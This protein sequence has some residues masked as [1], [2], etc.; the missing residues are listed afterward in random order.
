MNRPAEAK[1]KKTP[2]L[3][4]NQVK[5]SGGEANASKKFRIGELLVSEGYL[6]KEKLEQALTAQRKQE[7]YKPLGEVLVSLGFITNANLKRALRKHQKNINLGDMLISLGLIDKDQLQQLLTLQKKEGGRIGELLLKKGFVKESD[8]IDTLSE[9]MGI[10]KILPHVELIDK[11]L[12]KGVNLPYLNKHEAI[13]MFKEDDVLTVVMA[14]PLTI[15]TVNDLEKF[16]QCKVETAIAPSYEIKKS[17]KELE[18]YYGRMEFGKESKP[19]EFQKDL[20]IGDVK[21][22]GDTADGTKRIVNYIITNGILEGAS[23]IHIEP[24]Q[25]NLRISFRIDGVLHHKTDLP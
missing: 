6:S 17:L 5:N 25:H 24:Q 9:Q 21:L 16:F 2:P 4:K 10:P 23:D 7:D 11:A 13:P 19:S 15:E 3:V 18:R 12:L 14:D 1:T 20:V 8:L 22:S